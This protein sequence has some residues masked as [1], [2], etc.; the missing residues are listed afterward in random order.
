MTSHKE[1][2]DVFMIDGFYSH[3]QNGPDRPGKDHPSFQVNSGRTGQVGREMASKGQRRG[4]GRV[5]KGHQHCRE[6][7]KVGVTQ[8]VLKGKAWTKTKFHA[9][10]HELRSAFA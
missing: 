1:H 3:F 7:R 5:T 9:W 2:V 4:W 8:A 10:T 6:T